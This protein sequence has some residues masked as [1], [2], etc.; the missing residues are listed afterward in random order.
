M[1]AVVSR[2]GYLSKVIRLLKKIDQAI[3]IDPEVFVKS[4]WPYLWKK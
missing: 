4:D 3:S 1:Q 2:E